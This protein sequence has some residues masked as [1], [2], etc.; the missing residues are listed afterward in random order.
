W[1]ASYARSFAIQVSSDNLNWYTY[2]QDSEGT[3]GVD[4]FQRK[5]KARF[6][7]GIFTTRATAAGVV[8]SEIE[9]LNSARTD[10][11]TGQPTTDPTPGTTPTPGKSCSFAILENTYSGPDHWGTLR[12]KNTSPHAAEGLRFSFQVDANVTCDYTPEGWSL[13]QK[14]QTCAYRH[15]GLRLNPGEEVT[16]NVS[17]DTP[18]MTQIVG[19]QV[20]ANSCDGSQGPITPPVDPKPNL[21]WRKANL[22]VFES[23]PAPGSS[24]CNDFNGCTWEGQFAALE[25]KQTLQWVK[26]H[27]I[28]SVHSE[29]FAKYKLKTL[30]LREGNRQIDVK[31]YDK[32]SDSDCTDGTCC[33]NNK[34]ANGT[35]FLIDLE[36]FTAQKFGLTGGVIDWTCLDCED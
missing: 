17:T 14:G 32:C 33:T 28:A 25:G 21:K 36:I 6:V 11:T 20:A 30:R 19:L 12:F 24:E 34:K 13:E 27:K 10:T 3:G 2:A 18:T 23:Y 26:E 22:T 1:G 5:A 7:K 29:D 4:E 31:V 35:N 9:V 15:Q 8:L 16:V